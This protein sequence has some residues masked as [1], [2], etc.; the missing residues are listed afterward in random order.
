VA[1]TIERSLPL[2]VLECCIF[3]VL[4]AGAA[5]LLFANSEQRTRLTS[6]LA[7]RWRT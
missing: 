7:R 2:L 3:T 6:A 4:C 1:S 5:F